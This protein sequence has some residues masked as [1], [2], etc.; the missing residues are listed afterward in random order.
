MKIVLASGSPR[1][2][3]LLKL[4]VPKFEVLVSGIDETI[5]SNLRPQEQAM[6]LAYM[7]AK[8]VY[9]KGENDRIIIGSDTIVAKDNKVYGKPENR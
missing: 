8:D 4:I 1:R 5:V 7:K 9:K 2:K 6:R 3:E